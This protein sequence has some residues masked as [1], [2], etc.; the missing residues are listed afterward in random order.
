[1]INTT[2][3]VIEGR[4]KVHLLRSLREL[5]RYRGTIMAFAERTIR[6]NYKQA[7]LGIAWVVMVPLTNVVLY[8][9]VFGHIMHF[10]QHV[11]N[12]GAFVLGTQVPWQYMSSVTSGCSNAAIGNSGLMR[13]V[14][15]PREVPGVSTIISSGV[16]FVIVFLLYIALAPVLGAPLTWYLAFVP[17]LIIP[18]AVLGAGVGLGLGAFNIY[19]RDFSYLLGFVT[20]LWFWVTPII[21]PLSKIP[22]HLRG[23]YI[24]VN[25]AVGLFDAFSKVLTYGQMPD[26]PLLALSIGQTLVVATIGFAIFKRL[27]PLFA[28]VA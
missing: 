15:F 4:P 20:Q 12:Y 25:P 11:H 8:I 21:Y 27:E 28:D 26:L 1:V 16:N 2:E 5:W 17:L 6:V 13:K 10:N 22:E 7:A 9:F 24:A 3:L 19:Y 23:L 14:Y 18:V